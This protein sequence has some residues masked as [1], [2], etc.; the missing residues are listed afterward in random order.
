MLLITDKGHA[1]NVV[2]DFDDPSVLWARSQDR[3]SIMHASTFLAADVLEEPT[4]D[5][6]F[7][8][9][10]GRQEW[11]DYLKHVTFE[12]DAVKM[13]PAVA[14]ARGHEHPIS[15]VVED[16]FYALSHNRPDGSRPAWL[17]GGSRRR[18]ARKVS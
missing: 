7:R 1:F 4:W 8:I 10:I 14:Q 9:A 16:V 12:T 11:A 2:V 13:K 18:K 15:R 17:T 3:Q 6:E 5:Y